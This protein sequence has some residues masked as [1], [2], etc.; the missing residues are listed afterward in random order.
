MSIFTSI[1]LAALILPMSPF[2]PEEN[3]MKIGL[4]RADIPTLF[5]HGVRNDSGELLF[6]VRY[7]IR[8]YR[9]A[10]YRIRFD[11]RDAKQPFPAEPIVSWESSPFTIGDSTHANSYK[12]IPLD[13]PPGKYRMT[14]SLEHF[15]EGIDRETRNPF[16]FWDSFYADTYSPVTIR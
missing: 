16:A 3:G 7:Q 8:N 1:A 13:C 10:W 9:P 4:A 12:I 14:V 2:P 11:F 15:I 5:L 6:P